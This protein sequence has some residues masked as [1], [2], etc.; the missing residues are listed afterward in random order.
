MALTLARPE[1]NPRGGT[2][3]ALFYVEVRDAAG[4]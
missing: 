3:L 4:R 2:G 1:G